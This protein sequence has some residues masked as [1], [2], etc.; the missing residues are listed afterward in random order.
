MYIRYTLCAFDIV[1]KIVNIM[2]YKSHEMISVYQIVLGFINTK[3]E[4]Q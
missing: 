4:N 1:D 3:V 2:T